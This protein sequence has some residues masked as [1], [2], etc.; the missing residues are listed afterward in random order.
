ME[1]ILKTP[2]IRE[3]RRS[4]QIDERR[5]IAR[6]RERGGMG[7]TPKQM[8][9]PSVRFVK[10]GDIMIAD[11]GP[12]IR[13]RWFGRRLR[14]RTWFRCILSDKFETQSDAIAEMKRLW[15]G[16]YDTWWIKEA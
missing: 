3:N 10:C 1:R 15:D 12:M 14:G 6:R 9:L 11:R 4:L 2:K 7:W 16:G 13:N 5:T 8:G